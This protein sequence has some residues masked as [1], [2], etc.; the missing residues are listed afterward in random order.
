MH[1]VYLEPHIFCIRT[2]CNASI[3][4]NFVDLSDKVFSIWQVFSEWAAKESPDDI[5]ILCNNPDER[6]HDLIR[7]FTILEAAG[8]IVENPAGEVLMIHRLGKWDLPKGKL[9]DDETADVG[10]MREVEEECGIST[11]TINKKLPQT[12]HVYHT[13]NEGWIL[14]RTQWYGMH[15][16]KHQHPTPQASENITQAKWLNK[17]EAAKLLPHAYRSIADLMH[18]Y[19][20]QL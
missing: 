5:H 16:T 7:C 19:L 1:I 12:H 14:K 13:Q 17:S 3:R 10:A 6:F 15:I 18:F 4:Q 9:D 20:K 11:L 2:D 8:G